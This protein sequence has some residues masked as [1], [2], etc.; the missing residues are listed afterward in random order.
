MIRGM[1][2]L[3]DTSVARPFLPPFLPC[4]TTLPQSGGEEVV[5][6]CKASV[7]QTLKA[8]TPRNRS[9][10][11]AYVCSYTTDELSRTS[12]TYGLAKTDTG[13]PQV[14]L[15][16]YLGYEYGHTTIMAMGILRLRL[17]AYYICGYGRT[18][19]TSVLNSKTLYWK[20]KVSEY[21]YLAGWSSC[22]LSVC[23][24]A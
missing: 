10:A 12:S 20:S 15:W 2:D 23:G 14:R 17:Q 16:A 22:L 5:W 21:T 11:S 4:A 13:I 1:N 24:W 9:N 3:S 19:L 6:L 7:I 8:E 18:T